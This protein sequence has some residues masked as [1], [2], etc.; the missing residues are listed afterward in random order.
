MLFCDAAVSDYGK[1]NCLVGNWL[2]IWGEAVK[3][4]AI[5]IK[6]NHS[7]NLTVYS[8]IFVDG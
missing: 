2:H 7:D 4:I 8:K 3:E 1:S 5:T 6:L